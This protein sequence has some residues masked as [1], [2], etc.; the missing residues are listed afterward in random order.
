MQ[1]YICDITKLVALVAV[2]FLTTLL[3][4]HIFSPSLFSWH[5]DDV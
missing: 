2:D 3:D 5:L 4:F 1:S